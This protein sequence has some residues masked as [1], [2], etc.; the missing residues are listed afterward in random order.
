MAAIAIVH[1]TRVA[2]G[3]LSYGQYEVVA[4]PDDHLVQLRGPRLRHAP[5]RAKSNATKTGA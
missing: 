1:A 5:L 4:A 3:D 2:V